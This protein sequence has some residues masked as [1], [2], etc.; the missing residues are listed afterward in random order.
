DRVHDRKYAGAAEVVALDRLEIGKQPLHPSGILARA[1]R[2]MGGEERIDLPAVEHRIEPLFG[3][4]PVDGHIGGRGGQR[5]PPAPPAPRPP[6]PRKIHRARAQ[7]PK[8][9]LK[10]PL[11]QIPASWP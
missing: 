2:D 7:L 1:G 9:S 5:P 8:S 6:P 3:R 4:E 11:A 10:A